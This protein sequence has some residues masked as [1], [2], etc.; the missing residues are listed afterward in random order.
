[1]WHSTDFRS[2]ISIKEK[3]VQKSTAQG[4]VHRLFTE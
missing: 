3:E 2:H 1:M 4:G